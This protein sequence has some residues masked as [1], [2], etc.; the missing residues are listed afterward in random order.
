MQPL[1]ALLLGLGLLIP[2]L[3]AWNLAGGRG[4]VRGVAVASAVL[5]VGAMG[6][7]VGVSAVCEGNWLYGFGTCEVAGVR[8]NLLLLSTVVTVLVTVAVTLLVVVV[9]LIAAWRGRAR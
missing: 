6:M 7:I 2:A 3:L 5:I 4:W 8:A 1:T 9:A